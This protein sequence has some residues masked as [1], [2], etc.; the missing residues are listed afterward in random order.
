MPIRPT[1]GS[2]NFPEK[3]VEEVEQHWD[4]LIIGAGISGLD[5]AYHLKVLNMNKTRPAFNGFIFIHESKYHEKC[6]NQLYNFLGTIL[7]L[8]EDYML[9]SN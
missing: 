9:V 3:M 4:C 8:D 5:A 7:E 6:N 2:H 1:Q